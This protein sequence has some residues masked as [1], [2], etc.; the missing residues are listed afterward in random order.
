MVIARALN[1]KITIKQPSTGQDSW[2]QPLTTWT[3]LYSPWA[4]VTTLPRAQSGAEQITG[5][6]L[7]SAVTYLFKVRFKEGVNS[8]MRVEERFQGVTTVYDIKQV[9]VDIAGRDYMI[10]VCQ[11]GGLQG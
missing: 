4:Q 9:Q 6:Q 3:T 7:I 1:R 5:D 2:G 8:K 10:L 11:A